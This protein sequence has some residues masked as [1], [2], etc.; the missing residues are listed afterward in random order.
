MAK[1]PFNR[2]LN[3]TEYNFP[4]TYPENEKYYIFNLEQFLIENNY[5]SVIPE[6]IKAAQPILASLDSGEIMI[7]ERFP[8]SSNA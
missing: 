8:V 1:L 7:V 5:N 6:L 4:F 2:L 3:T